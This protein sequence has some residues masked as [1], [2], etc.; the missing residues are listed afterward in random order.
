MSQCRVGR[1]AVVSAGSW[2]T[3][4]AKILADPEVCTDVVVHARRREVADAINTRRCNPFYFPDVQ[5]PGS[6]RATTDVAAALDGADWL[7]L[8]V[9]AQSQRANLTAWAPFVGPGTVVVSAMKGIEAGTGMR[10]SEVISEVAGVPADR[11]AVLSGPNLAREVMAGRPAAATIACPDESTCD[12]TCHAS[13]SWWAP[14][15]SR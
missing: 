12:N 10:A 1:A 5:L 4:I 9:P 3:P 13:S 7:V 15:P 8:S 6:V 14:A 2:G 11:V